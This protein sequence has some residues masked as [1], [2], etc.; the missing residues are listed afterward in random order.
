MKVIPHGY[1][2]EIIPSG[3][4]IHAN[5]VAELIN[6]L[7]K[8]YKGLQPTPGEERHHI[9]VPGFDSVESLFEPTEIEEVHLVPDFS[10]DKSGGLFKVLIGAVIVGAAFALGPAGAGVLAGA[11]SS[12]L[13]TTSTVALF[14]ASIALGGLIQ[15]LSPAPEVDTPDGTQDEGSRILGTPKNTVKLGTRIPIIYGE[16]RAY[17]H[18]ISFN[19]DATET[20]TAAEKEEFAPPPPPAPTNV[21]ATSQQ[22]YADE[23]DLS[24]DLPTDADINNYAYTDPAENTVSPFDSGR[25]HLTGIVITQKRIYEE[26]GTGATEGASQTLYEFDDT[27]LTSFT[28]NPNFQGKAKFGVHLKYDNGESSTIAETSEVQVLS[29][30]HGR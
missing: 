20:A 3:I 7:S 27:T 11:G 16:H 18:Y 1:L 30:P 19:I 26:Q 6:G 17:G 24:W 23:I 25:T 12:A 14:G 22:T 9:R 28:V 2:A 8:Q 10:G 21:S 13:I 5:S 15:L 4:E 29:T